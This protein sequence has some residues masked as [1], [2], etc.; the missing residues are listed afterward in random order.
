[1]GNVLLCLLDG[2]VVESWLTFQIY[3]VGSRK[4]VNGGQ[5][6]SLKKGEFYYYGDIRKVKVAFG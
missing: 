1:M 5:A 4:R 6:K 3:C 2:V